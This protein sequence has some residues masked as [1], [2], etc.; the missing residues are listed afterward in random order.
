MDRIYSPRQLSNQ[1]QRAITAA[2]PFHGLCGG[3]CW[4]VEVVIYSFKL[5]NPFDHPNFETC[6]SEDQC[7]ISPIS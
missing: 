6:I 3:K 1:D 5:N 2:L 4:N 7:F